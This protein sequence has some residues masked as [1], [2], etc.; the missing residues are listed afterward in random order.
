MFDHVQLIQ[1]SKYH[2]KIITIFLY[3]VFWRKQPF[4]CVQKHI[5]KYTFPKHEMLR[6]FCIWKKKTK[7][8]ST[9][10]FPKWR[11]P[12]GISSVWK[13]SVAGSTRGCGYLLVVGGCAP[14]SPVKRK[15]LKKSTIFDKFWNLCPYRNAFSP[16]CAP[17][18]FCWK[19]RLIH[20]KYVYM[21]NMIM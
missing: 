15:E 4:K 6:N 17:K 16:W 21:C 18:K 12:P 2:L 19:E 9:F 5:E 20:Y 3:N 7:L 8:I 13:G 14:F 1:L 10:F 11:Q